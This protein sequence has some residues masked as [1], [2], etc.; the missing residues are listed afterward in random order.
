MFDRRL[1]HS[2]YA[3]PTAQNHK[4][5]AGVYCFFLS[6]EW[7]PADGRYRIEVAASDTRENARSRTWTSRSRKVRQG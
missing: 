5:K 1:F 2:I 4:G 7:K 3:P 6:H